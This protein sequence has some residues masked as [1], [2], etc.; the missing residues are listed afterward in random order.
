[1]SL[2]GAFCYHLLSPTTQAPLEPQGMQK[3][4]GRSMLSDE[5]EPFCPHMPA[6]TSE[7][8]SR[9]EK[10]TK[11]DGRVPGRTLSQISPPLPFTEFENLPLI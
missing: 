10:L 4:K 7:L 3:Q 9:G 5:G 1:M 6:F 2:R 11:C 8:M